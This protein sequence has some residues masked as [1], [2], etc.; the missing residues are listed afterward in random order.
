M[1][2]L[3]LCKSFS[4]GPYIAGKKAF[5]AGVADDQVSTF[6]GMTHQILPQYAI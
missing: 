1:S 6:T 3:R 5:V 2:G 4:W